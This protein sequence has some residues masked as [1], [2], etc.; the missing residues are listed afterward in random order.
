MF[1]SYKQ[2]F[3][4]ATGLPLSI[5]PPTPD[6]AGDPSEIPAC[7]HLFCSPLAVTHQACPACRALQM[8][9]EAGAKL[10]PKTLK[11]VAGLCETAVPVRVGPRLV[12]F[13]QTGGVLVK[14]PTRRQFDKVVREF[15]RLGAPPHP[16]TFEETYR[17]TRVLAP[18]Q[19]ESTVQLLAIFASQLSACANQLVL[20]RDAR[21]SPTIS[22]ARRLIDHGFR[23]DL[24]L[25]AVARQV[26][27]S[28]SY[29]SE[30]FKKGTGLNFVDYVAR[31]RVG[32]ARTLLQNPQYRVSEVAFEVGFHSL[33][34]F[35][36]SFHRIAGMS[37]RAY[38]A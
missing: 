32:E 21:E 17:A 14:A 27:L 36:R 15:L 9:L 23:N 35:N 28:P 1:R 34:Q 38:R 18:E 29:F 4:K 24:S 16:K 33:S 8:R 13:L 20:H 7:S 12:A 31:V 19:Y 10:Q 30:Q 3:E 25:R 6:H 26:N 22:R 5:H 2:A 37:P 11:C